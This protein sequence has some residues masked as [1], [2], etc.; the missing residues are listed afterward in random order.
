MD[1]VTPKQKLLKYHQ[2]R[3]PILLIF[4]VV[5]ILGWFWLALKSSPAPWRQENSTNKI[6]EPNKPS[7][8]W[9]QGYGNR[10]F[11]EAWQATRW[12]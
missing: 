10:Y 6:V 12:Y 8:K 3:Q 9:I 7:R 4:E 2:E 1:H 5:Y 11:P